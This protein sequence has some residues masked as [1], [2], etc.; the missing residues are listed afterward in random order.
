MI[1]NNYKSLVVITLETR[2]L[3]QGNFMLCEKSSYVCI[4]KRGC[5]FILLFL[6]THNSY[7]MVCK[8]PTIHINKLNQSKKF[9]YKK[10]EVTRVFNGDKNGVIILLHGLNDKASSMEQMAG[11]FQDKGFDVVLGSLSGH[12][13]D[14]DELLT[15]N[16]E[17]WITD[18]YNIYCVAASIAQK[19]SVP[20]F[21]VGYSFSNLMFLKF[22]NKFSITN[23]KKMVLL[24]PSLSFT[25]KANALK[26][27]FFL[28]DKTVIP[29]Y[30]LK[31][32]RAN[33]GTSIAAYKAVFNT[34]KE[35]NSFFKLKSNIPVL[36][37]FHKLDEIVDS[38][39]SEKIIKSKFFK[40]KT[41]YLDNKDHLLEKEINHLMID[42][43]SLGTKNWNM[44]M[45]SILTFL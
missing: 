3:D 36:S 10:L 33:R 11:L 17:E 20:L 9:K 5:L 38:K 1:C 18:I 4:F 37:F 16:Q 19:K 41:I 12:R 28:P 22:I 6:F 24:A 25:L 2:D 34:Q 39:E 8:Q 44:M 40:S 42:E 35:M 31:I 45:S 32:Y 30:N 29:S 7:G 43:K 21:F 23:I 15:V 14:V 13:G 26:L 27:L